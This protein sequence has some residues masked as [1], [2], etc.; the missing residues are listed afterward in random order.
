LS[1]YSKCRIAI[2]PALFPDVRL[3]VITVLG[4]IYRK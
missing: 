1:L 3:T 4:C 2:L